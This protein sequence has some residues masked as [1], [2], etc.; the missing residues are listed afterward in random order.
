M[1]WLSVNYMFFTGLC[2]NLYGFTLV[3][4]AVK[5]CSPSTLLFISGGSLS[6]SARTALVLHCTGINGGRVVLNELLS[7]LPLCW[8]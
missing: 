8:V 7:L 5:C 2:L 1:A 4:Y 6:S 3:S